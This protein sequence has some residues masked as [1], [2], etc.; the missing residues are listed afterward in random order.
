MTK[1]ILKRILV[2]HDDLIRAHSVQYLLF[3]EDEL[4][5]VCDTVPD[6]VKMRQAVIERNP[7]SAVI[8][9]PPDPA[10]E[11]WIAQA[12]AAR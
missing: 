2:D 3:R 8:V 9:L 1:A 10:R 4:I 12:L 11:A 6:V 5:A 7:D